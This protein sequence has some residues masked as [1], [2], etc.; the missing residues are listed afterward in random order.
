MNLI[1]YLLCLLTNYCSVAK[2]V[3]ARI[4]RDSH[5]L[6]TNVLA[7]LVILDSITFDCLRLQGLVTLF[8]SVS[9]YYRI[10]VMK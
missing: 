2:I 3:H 5:K 8:V 10:F 1:N 4:A 9:N 7:S 6:N